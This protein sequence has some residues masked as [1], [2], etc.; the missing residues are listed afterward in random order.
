MVFDMTFSDGIRRGMAHDSPNHP[1]I[2]V[3]RNG[4]HIDL[5]DW[6]KFGRKAKARLAGDDLPPSPHAPI[7]SDAESR[8]AMLRHYLRGRGMDEES[9]EQACDICKT[10]LEGG[11][12]EDELPTAGPGGARNLANSQS[13]EGGEKV[14]K[15]TGHFEK[16]PLL[17]TTAS[18]RERSVIGEV[19]YRSSPASDRSLLDELGVTRIKVG[20]PGS[21][22][23]DPAPPLTAKGR[24]LAEDAAARPRK[25]LRKMFPDLERIGIGDFP[26][27]R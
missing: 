13:R 6:A 2:Y 5:R 19:E 7:A 11:E 10:E 25:S 26:K 21:S 27:R 9:I 17:G 18:N 20:V 12:V 22:Q 14:F 3:T 24:Q 23:F 16:R 15:S 8:I 4:S 1:K